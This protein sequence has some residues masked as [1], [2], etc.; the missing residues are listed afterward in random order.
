MIK[1]SWLIILPIIIIICYGSVELTKIPLKLLLVSLTWSLSLPIIL[2]FRHVI[3]WNYI[4][5]R[6]RSEKIEYEE[7][8]WYDGQIWEK[9]IEMREKDFLTAQYHIKPIISTLNNTLY[10]I[11]LTFITCLIFIEF[12]FYK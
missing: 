4:Y 3:S 2:L 11:L 5:K 12:I 6:L 7:S 10:I 1:F 8:G 9:T